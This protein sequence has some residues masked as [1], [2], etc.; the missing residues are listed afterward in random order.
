LRCL[1][2]RR[3]CDYNEASSTPTSTI[4]VSSH[5][6]DPRI[7]PQHRLATTTIVPFPL[8]SSKSGTSALQLLSH[9]V[10]H[11]PTILSMPHASTTLVLTLSKSSCL[12][13]NGLLALAACHLRCMTPN[14]PEH[15]VAEHFQQAVT[16][17]ELQ[18]LLGKPQAELGQE[19]ANAMLMCAMLLNILAFVLP[20]GGDRNDRTACRNGNRSTNTGRTTTSA[21]STS[22]SQPTS[23]W[24]FDWLGLQTGIRPLFVYMAPYVSQSIAFME[25]IFLTPSDSGA[26]E[27][28]R[29]PTWAAA[30]LAQGYRE[31]PELWTEHFG[32]PRCYGELEDAFTRIYTPAHGHTGASGVSAG[33]IESVRMEMDVDT[34]VHKDCLGPSA[35]LMFRQ[36]AITV[37][38]N[39]DNTPESTATTT[40]T[41]HSFASDASTTSSTITSASTTANIYTIPASILSFLFSSTTRNKPTRNTNIFPLL[42]FAVKATPAFRLALSMR[43]E[44]A[45]WLYCFWLGLMQDVYPDHGDAGQKDEGGTWWS[46]GRVA[47]EWEDIQQYLVELRLERREGFEGRRWAVLMGELG[48]G[49]HQRN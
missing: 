19:N 45:L 15:R 9:L 10:L 42:Q 5:P 20:T 14:I 26:V 33:G 38:F 49:G 46:R 24:D 47:Q 21:T 3:S 32:I 11:G 28:G 34:D 40:S 13:R 22:I 4:H 48:L 6:N 17:A 12:I 25:G 37:H 2:N 30:A 18:C 44:R 1:R 27:A 31:M 43:D 23:T 35:P 36:D 7:S 41:P 16:L 39:T 8:H 29:H